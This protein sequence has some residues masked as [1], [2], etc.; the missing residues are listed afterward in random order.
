MKIKIKTIVRRILSLPLIIILI[1][2][3]WLFIDINGVWKG[4]LDLTDE[5]IANSRGFM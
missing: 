3:L 1:P 5:D 2:L 4:F